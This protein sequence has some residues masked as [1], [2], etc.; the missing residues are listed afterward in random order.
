MHYLFLRIHL[1]KG[2]GVAEQ[3]FVGGFANFLSI[4]NIVI[5]GRV[6]LSWFPQAQGK[7]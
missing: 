6:L 1:I 2:Y 5:T 3:V 7:F 4:F